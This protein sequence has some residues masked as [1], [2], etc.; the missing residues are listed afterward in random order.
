MEKR[1][2]REKRT[3]VYCSLSRKGIMAKWMLKLY[4]PGL[5]DSAIIEEALHKDA[6]HL[7]KALRDK[8]REEQRY[9]PYV[10]TCGALYEAFRD[11]LEDKSLMKQ[12]KAF[13]STF[14]KEGS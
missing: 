9:C 10:E 14:G 5:S 12:F 13:I 3:P 7:P 4:H 1:R 2:R 11:I 6:Q 8:L